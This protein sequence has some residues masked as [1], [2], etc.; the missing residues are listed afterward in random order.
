MAPPSR[1]LRLEL[2]HRVCLQRGIIG[3]LHCRSF[4]GRPGEGGGHWLHNCVLHLLFRGFVLHHPGVAAGQRGI[5]TGGEVWTRCYEEESGS[6][7]GED[8]V[9]IG[10]LPCPDGVLHRDPGGI[11][12]IGGARWRDWRQSWLWWTIS[13]GDGGG[14]GVYLG[15]TDH[16]LPGVQ[17]LPP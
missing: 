17:I 7:Q 2:C 8:G 11:W 16:T 13:G 14:D 9:I 6:N 10:S 4:G 5:G 1:H 15:G 12:G 3:R